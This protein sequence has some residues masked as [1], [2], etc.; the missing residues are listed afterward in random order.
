M[1]FTPSHAIVAIPFARSPIPAGAVAIGAMA[2]DLPLFFPVVP[3]Y[4]AT[5]GFPSLLWTSLPI[6]VLLFVIWRVVIRPAAARLLPAP[7]GERLPLDWDRVRR[8]TRPA[9]FAVLTVAGALIGVLSHVIWDLFTHPGRL[10]SEW[11]PILAAQWGGLSLTSWAQHASSAIGLLGVGVWAVLAFRAA[12][13]VRR[14]DP[15]AV[16]MLRVAAW[17]AAAVTLVAW[18]AAMVA[19]DGVP[20]GYRTL[21]DTAFA[22]GTGAGATILVIALAASILMRWARRNAADSPAG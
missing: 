4:S 7:L 1:P 13:R 21:A 20:T 3:S 15:P 22:A 9:L 10:G 16:R 11:L 6:A 18:S 12:P 19:R 5:H 8:P 2:P 17:S 14:A